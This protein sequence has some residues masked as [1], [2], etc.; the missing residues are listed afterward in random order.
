MKKLILLFFLFLSL[1]L[2][3]QGFWTQKADFGGVARYW[4]IGFS[5]NGKGYAG[6][7]R[8]NGFAN[9]SDLWEYDPILNSWT[10]KASFP[11]PARYSSSVFVL[12]NKA[13][14][15]SGA[16]WN[17]APGGYTPYNDVWEYNPATN[18]WLQKNNFPGAGRHDA[19]A[20][21]YAGMGYLCFGQAANQ[22]RLNDLWQYNPTTDTWTQKATFP[23]TSRSAGIQFGYQ[24]YGYV[25]LGRDDSD[26]SLG[27]IWRYDCSTDT[28]F[29]LAN[30]PDTS[31]SSASTFVTDKRAYVVGGY[32]FQSNSYAPELWEYYPIS[33]TWVQKEDFPPNSRSCGFGFSINNRGYY[34]TGCVFSTFY[35]DFWEYTPSCDTFNSNVTLI[36]STVYAI[37]SGATYQWLNCNN[38]FAPIPS[39]TNQSY[40]PAVSGNYA[41]IVTQNICSDTSDCIAVTIC[42]SINTNVVLS[43]PTIYSL[44]SGASYQ[45]LNCNIGFAAIDNETNQSYTPSVNGNYA[46]IVS[47]NGC[48]DTSECIAI[49]TGIEEVDNSGIEFYPNPTQGEII[50]D[51]KN[52]QLKSGVELIDMN[53]KIIKTFPASSLNTQK[54]FV[55]EIS[56]GHYLLLFYIDT[57][58]IYKE[59]IIN[60]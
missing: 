28:W 21:S 14:F 4:A 26:Q 20:F 3:S 40:S 57:K 44:A 16:Y 51:L 58:K 13:Y 11:G 19:F 18:S 6:L 36:G 38:G 10:Q 42:D 9:S 35:K 15:C 33:D 59:I 7:G 2:F 47:Q 30:F 34:G 25:G 60:K 39:E 31:L 32:N 50:V 24:K 27:D 53:G 52:N 37:A 45:W 48:S 23:G 54:L 56:N 17:G 8:G 5:I 55:G 49:Y 43:G 46:V 1:N 41:V 22:S 29:Q 12:N